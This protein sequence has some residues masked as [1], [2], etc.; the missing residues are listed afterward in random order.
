MHINTVAFN[1]DYTPFAKSRDARIA[2]WCAKNNCAL[3]VEDDYSLLPMY[4][5]WRVFTPYY[6]HC[7]E[8]LA[9]LTFGQRKPPI[10]FAKIKQPQKNIDQRILKLFETKSPVSRKNAIAILVR[11]K[12]REF[13]NYDKDRDYMY[14]NATT[15]LSAYIKFGLVSIR[16]VYK[17]VLDSY[18]IDHGIIRELLWRDYYARIVWFNPRILEGES[19]KKYELQWDNKHFAAWA[20]GETGFPIVDAA[21][22]ELNTTGYMHNR[23]RMIVASFLVKDLHCD[24]RLGERY[25]ATKLTDYDPCSNSG[26]W[27]GISSVG[28]DASQPYFRIMNPWRQSATYDPDCKYIK[29]WI[30]ELAKS[31]PKEIHSWFKFHNSSYIKPIVDH[32]ESADKYKQLY[33]SAKKY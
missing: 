14:L 25:F 23:C 27:Q 17:V 10:N 5:E 32:N 16:E 30:P 3:L 18:G 8:Q 9:Q 2:N 1:R 13:A 31:K 24:W 22:R 19:L 12:N 11:I 4:R 15:R 33:M 6:K 29:K 20:K 21:M 26:G 28:A 7:L